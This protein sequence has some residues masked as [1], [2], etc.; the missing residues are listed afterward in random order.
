MGPGPYNCQEAVA[1]RGCELPIETLLRC[2]ALGPNECESP[3]RE[4]EREEKKPQNNAVF[5]V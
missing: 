4:R 3:G 2:V 5:S 1:F